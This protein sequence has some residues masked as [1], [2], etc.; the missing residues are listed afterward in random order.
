M[1]LV[2][3]LYWATNGPS[4]VNIFRVS[5]WFTKSLAGH[6]CLNLKA[7]EISIHTNDFD[8]DDIDE[9]EHVVKV[10][11]IHIHHAYVD[12]LL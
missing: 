11:K 1:E 8:Y 3:L 12:E 9:N 4:Q 5:Q 2:E 10:K 6:C 7:S